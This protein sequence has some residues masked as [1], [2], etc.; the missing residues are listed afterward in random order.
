M[1]ARLALLLALLAPPAAAIEL[2]EVDPL[3]RAALVA[4]TREADSFPD[5][6]EAEVWLTDMSTRLARR[7]P[8]VNE[9]LQLLR[10]VHAEATR[11]E[12]PPELVL[13][14]IEIESNFDRWALSVVGARGLMQVMPFWKREI[15]REDD[16]LL[17]TATN[18]RYGCTILKHYLDRERGRMIPA[19]Q[20]YNG[21]VGGRRY[22]TK[23]LNAL[24]RRWFR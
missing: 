6:F 17:D 12:L 3:L 10:L 2:P 24:T 7:M 14:V 8:D 19:L 22:S 18:L 20:R 4:A 23:V 11:A 13:A 1:T 5:R 21:A 16:N 15:G 9:R